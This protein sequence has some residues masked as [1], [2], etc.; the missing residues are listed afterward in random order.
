MWIVRVP[1]STI[2]VDARRPLGQAA[3]ELVGRTVTYQPHIDMFTADGRIVPWVASQSDLDADD[4]AV[5]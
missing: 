5:V 3:P 1:G 4:W 2:T